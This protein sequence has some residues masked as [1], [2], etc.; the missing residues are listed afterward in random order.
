MIP[1]EISTAL[2]AKFPGAILDSKL[3]GIIDPFLIVSR[4]RIRDVALYLRDGE[5]LAFD[6]L[7]CLSGVDHTG[8]A[9]HRLPSPLNEMEPQDRAESERDCR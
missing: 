2:Q 5:E 8:E 6:S 7:M 9:L 1:Q 3:D 4:E